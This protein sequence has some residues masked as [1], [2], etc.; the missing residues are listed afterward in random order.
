MGGGDV[1]M[2]PPRYYIQ[3]RGHREW[4]ILVYDAA[5]EIWCEPV[6]WYATRAEAREAVLG[7]KRW[8]E[9]VTQKREGKTHG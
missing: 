4:G 8:F 9:D 7:D 6:R 2:K 5:R 3:R 1:P